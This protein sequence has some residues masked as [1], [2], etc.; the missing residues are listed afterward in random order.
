MKLSTVLLAVN[1]NRDYYEFAPFVHRAWTSLFPGIRCIIIFIGKQTPECLQELEKTKSLI[2]FPPIPNMHTAQT[3]QLARLL[4]PALCPNDGAVIISDIDLIPMCRWY[5]ENAIQACHESQLVVFRGN[6]FAPH[7]GYPLCFYAAHPSVWAKIFNIKSVADIE[8][9]LKQWKTPN[10][11]L[12]KSN[13]YNDQLILA[14]K[15]HMLQKNHPESIEVF[16]DKHLGFRRLCRSEFDEITPEILE[17]IK[18]QQYTDYHCKRP[19]KQYETLNN[20]ILEKML[21]NNNR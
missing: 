18:N 7:T 5:Y 11:A 14:R 2:R 1:D 3:A 4:F 8:T 9:K 20:E 10:Y 12:K 6:I 15:V 19:F 17:K 16:Y 21:D 13:W